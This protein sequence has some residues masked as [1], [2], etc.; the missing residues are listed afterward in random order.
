MENV[1]LEAA[2]IVA[3]A[4]ISAALIVGAIV[5]ISQLWRTAFDK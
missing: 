5:F 4:I 1:I 3:D 2:E